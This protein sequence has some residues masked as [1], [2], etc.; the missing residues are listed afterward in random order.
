MVGRSAETGNPGEPQHE[1]HNRSVSRTET[2]LLG[3]SCHSRTHGLFA[4]RIIHGSRGTR[5]APHPVVDIF[6]VDIRTVITQV[7]RVGDQS[8][9][10][11][12]R[13]RHRHGDKFLF[14]TAQR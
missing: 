11:V 4:H 10:A 2:R 6:L 9:K 8:V 5:Q 7:P 1:G 3:C 14:A 12:I 13:G